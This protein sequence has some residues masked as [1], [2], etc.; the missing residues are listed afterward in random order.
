MTR[1]EKKLLT[2]QSIKKAA[3]MC[4]E[5]TD[6]DKTLVGQISK[7]AG[8]AHGT[9]Y[10]HFKDKGELLDALLDDF[11]EELLK[12]C[13]PL[14]EGVSLSPEKTYILI[15]KLCDLIL[16]HME[17]NKSFVSIYVLRMTKGASVKELREGINPKVVGF[18]S[19]IMGSIFKLEKFEGIVLIQGI[20]ALWMRVILQYFD[21]GPLSRDRTLEIL[22]KS[23]IGVLSNFS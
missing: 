18:F 9:F 23:T 19:E 13:R 21:G 22:Q 2:K 6:V 14:F 15:P 10:V 5:K 11:N 3:V 16:T 12:K 20:L 8:V 4:F 7:E 17:Q 1:Q